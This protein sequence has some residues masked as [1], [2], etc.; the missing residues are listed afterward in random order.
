MIWFTSDCH[1][2]H[3][4]S[5]LWEPRG[6]NDQYEMNREIIKNW[7]EQVQADDD[8]YLLGDVMLNDNVEGLKCLKAL[9]GRI[10]IVLGNHDSNARATLYKS[11][12]N[13]VEVERAI[14][15]EAEGYKFYLTHYPTITSNF[16]EKKPLERRVI[17]ICGHSHTKDKFQDMNKGLIYHVE[18][19]AHNNAPVSIDTVISDIKKYIERKK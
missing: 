17:N 18:F 9:K 15:L 2:C 11:C 13:V 16:D 5:F 6:F 4:K 10:H 8:V 14:P 19:D 7:N 12:Y 1:F 3:E